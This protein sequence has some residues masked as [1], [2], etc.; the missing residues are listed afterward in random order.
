MLAVYAASQSKDDPLS[1][2]EVGERPAPE[3]R[4]G[5][6][7][8]AL[9]TAGL[10]HHDLFSLMGVGLPADRPL[11]VTVRRLAEP[12]TDRAWALRRWAGRRS[13]PATRSGRAASG[14]A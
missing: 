3:P 6:T 7:T 10:N 13:R 4:P 11:L 12:L 1:G 9:R 5:W 14:G 8:V 2:L